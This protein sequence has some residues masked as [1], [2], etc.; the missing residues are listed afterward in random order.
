M[1]FPRVAI[2]TAIFTPSVRIQARV[3]TQVRAFVFGEE[4]L[5]VIDEKGRFRCRRIPFWV[6]PA[7]FFH[8]RRVLLDVESLERI[9]WIDGSPALHT[10]RSVGRSDCSSP[11]WWVGRFEQ[12]DLRLGEHFLDDRQGARMRTEL[13]FPTV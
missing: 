13:R 6:D 10:H 12:R 3:K 8:G 2:T 4:R 5:G 9:R 7:Q 11:D 1:K